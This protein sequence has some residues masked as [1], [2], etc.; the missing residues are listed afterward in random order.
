MGK[1]A[2]W[3]RHDSSAGRDMKLLKIKGIHTHWGVGVFWEVIEVLRDQDGYKHEC[4]ESSLQLLCSLIGCNDVP[5]FL[6]WYRDT[7]RFKLFSEKDGFFFSESLIARMRKWE[8]TKDNGSK[9]GIKKK[10][11]KLQ[12][13]LSEYGSQSSSELSSEHGSI[14]EE[15]RIEEEKREEKENLIKE[16]GV[17]SEN[18]GK[19]TTNQKNKKTHKSPKTGIKQSKSIKNGYKSQYSDM[20][21]AQWEWEKTNFLKDQGWKDGYLGR[22]NYGAKR[23]DFQ[24]SEYIKHLDNGED[25]KPIGE[26]KRHFSNWNKGDL[27]KFNGSNITLY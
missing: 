3:F 4:D 19:N 14:R 18:G 26:L 5:K 8:S 9:G 2:F 23:L 10:I 6:S 15:K 24:L 20:D 27:Q 11:N 1:D 7:I 12:R 17:F 22:S 13:H 25:Y 16:N 21:K